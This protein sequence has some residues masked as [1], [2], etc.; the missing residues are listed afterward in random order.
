M[1]SFL[2][3]DT[4]SLCNLPDSDLV[5]G[6]TEATA[7]GSAGESGIA[8]VRLLCLNSL[9]ANHD[10]CW[11]LCPFSILEQVVIGKMSLDPCLKNHSPRRLL[12]NVSVFVLSSDVNWQWDFLK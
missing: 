12:M 7:E 11:D 6:V 2:S 10:A 9:S 1:P 5:N 4:N 3:A 8:S